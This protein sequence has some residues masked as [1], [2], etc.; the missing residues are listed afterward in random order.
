MIELTHNSNIELA[1]EY[2]PDGMVTI[3][4]ADTDTQTSSAWSMTRSEF[5]KRLAGDRP[6]PKQPDPVVEAFG[7][8]EPDSVVSQTLLNDLARVLASLEVLEKST[9]PNKDLV[10]Y[11]QRRKELLV[12]R[13]GHYFLPGLYVASYDRKIN[14]DGRNCALVR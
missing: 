5:G 7:A 14:Y 11:F 8:E 1:I 13:L 4:I 10:T 6:Q 12:D 9:C 2:C 3:A